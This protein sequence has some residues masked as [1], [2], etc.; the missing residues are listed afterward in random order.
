[1]PLQAVNH[2]G[3][4]TTVYLVDPAGKIASRPVTL[5]LQTSGEAEVVAGLGEGEQVVVSDRS[6]LKPGQEVHPHVVQM[7]Q[8]HD[9]GQE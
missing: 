8:Y 7:L 6:G 5:G 1:M 4:Q 2:E 3:D 9:S